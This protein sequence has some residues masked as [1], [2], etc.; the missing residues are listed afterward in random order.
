MIKA[1]IK[2]VLLITAIVSIGCLAVSYADSFTD[3]AA[4]N[5]NPSGGSASASGQAN[6]QAYDLLT[7]A[8]ATAQSSNSTADDTRKN[9]PSDYPHQIADNAYAFLKAFNYYSL[10]WL[11]I[12]STPSSNDLDSL[13]GSY[14]TSAHKTFK[15]QLAL[16]TGGSLIVEGKNNDTT[17]SVPSLYALDKQTLSIYATSIPS[18]DTNYATLVKQNAKDTPVP[19]DIKLNAQYFV[20]NASG[21]NLY[22]IA[23][24]SLQ[25]GTNALAVRKYTTFYNALNAIAS[26]NAYILNGHLADLQNNFKLSQTQM[27]LQNYAT[28]NKWLTHVNNEQSIGVIL[29]QLLLFNSQMYVLMTE[30]LATQKQLLASAAMTNALIIANSGFYEKTLLDATKK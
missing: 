11:Q 24:S 29:R 17:V 5:N 8:Q 22:H 6:T 14:I 10:N 19:Q 25:A 26:Y 21:I 13:F 16:L 15:N 28:D 2:Y 12:Y 7:E 1:Q 3:A 9:S 27:E 30:S 20:K 18:P 4:G 23:P